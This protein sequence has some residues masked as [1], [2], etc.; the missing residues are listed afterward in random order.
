MDGNII[1]PTDTEIQNIESVLVNG[2]PTAQFIGFASPGTSDSQARWRIKKLTY[3]QFGNPTTVRWAFD[4]SN[5]GG[6]FKKDL[7]WDDRSSYVYK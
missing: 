5:R 2:I 3:D 6:P 4:S 7:I 1:Y